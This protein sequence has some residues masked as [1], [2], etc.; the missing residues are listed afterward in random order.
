MTVKDRLPP[1]GGGGRLL[2]RT[3]ECDRLDTL[4]ARARSGASGVIVLRGG[5]GVGKS[6]LL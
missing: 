6:A 1:G 3:A 2:G 4:L 5:P